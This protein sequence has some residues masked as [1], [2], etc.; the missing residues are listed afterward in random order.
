MY[1]FFKRKNNTHVHNQDCLIL[2]VVIFFCL[3]FLRLFNT[4]CSAFFLYILRQQR[5]LI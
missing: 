4:D 2:V 3:I 1:Y 5:V